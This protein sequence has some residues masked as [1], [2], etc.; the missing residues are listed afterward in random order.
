MD[1]WFLLYRGDKV[2]LHRSGRSVTLIKSQ[3]H[4]RQNQQLMLNKQI[5]EA[6]TF[7]IIVQKPGMEDIGLDY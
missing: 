1:E 4:G 5:L 7:S 3:E 6:R 2:D